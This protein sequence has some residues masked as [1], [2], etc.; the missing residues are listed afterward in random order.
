MAAVV[1]IVM[2]WQ[3]Y[4]DSTISHTHTHTDS[5]TYTDFFKSAGSQINSSTVRS[6][7]AVM[8]WH[9]ISIAK[10]TLEA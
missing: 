8:Q 9:Y 1:I 7:I 6:I 4:I 2:I 3:L 5:L 10:H